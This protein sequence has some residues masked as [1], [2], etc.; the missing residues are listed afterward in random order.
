MLVLVEMRPASTQAPVG[1]NPA[2]QDLDG[3]AIALR[4]AHFPVLAGGQQNLHPVQIQSDYFHRFSSTLLSSLCRFLLLNLIHRNQI[5]NTA[6][7]INAPTGLCVTWYHSIGDLPKKPLPGIES[8]AY[9]F[10]R[11]A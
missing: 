4:K 3:S 10:W 7:A 5:A 9:S 2:Y 6:R 8:R 11:S 1:D